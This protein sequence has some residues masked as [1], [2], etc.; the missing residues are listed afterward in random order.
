MESVLY[1]AVGAVFGAV[2]FLVISLIRNKDTKKLA[3]E[4]IN[5]TEVQ[6]LQDLEI[7]ISKIK[8][9]FGS[10]S[11]DVLQKQNEL[12]G[13]ELE[14][15]KQLIDQRLEEMKNNLQSVE[16]MVRAFEKDRENKFGE[17]T[18]QLK[19]TV[20]QTNKL[21]ETTNKLHNVL[22]STKARRQWGERMA[23]D[24]LRLAGFIEGVNYLKQKSLETGSTIPDYT[25]LLP[26]KLKVNM[27]V[28]FPLDN[29]VNYIEAKE[30][31]QRE[32]YK[33]KFIKDVKARIKEVTSRDYINPEENTVD[34]VIVFIPNEQIYSFINENDRSVLDD[35]LKSKVILSSPITLYAIL[36]VIRQAV[37][38]FN[39]EKTAAQ[40]LSLL[41]GFNKQW[42][43]FVKSMDKMGKKIEEAQTEYNN[44]MSTRRNQL[45]RQLRQIE[46]LRTQKGIEVDEIKGG[47]LI[48]IESAREEEISC[49]K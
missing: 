11:L 49:K 15:K 40:M 12:G 22:A 29:Y 18:E 31:S 23:E 48:S 25:F 2:V 38:N 4:L 17:I 32:D 28:K 16:N 7:L 26:Q 6:K 45:E 35:A 20:E 46:D 33:N 21:Q 44:L 39:L 9:S 43:A 14:G 47:D 34:Y 5:Q 3:Q 41:G 24:V 42:E 13:K 10:L 30:D 19:N 36:A 8:D 27:D 37:D 1:F